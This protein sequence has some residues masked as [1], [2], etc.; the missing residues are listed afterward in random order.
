MTTLDDRPRLAGERPVVPL[1]RR[2]QAPSLRDGR[3]LAGVVLVLASV[4]LG[5]RVVGAAAR[6][7]PVVALTRDLPAGHVVTAG[8]LTTQ[9]VHLTSTKAYVTAAGR[10]E[11]LG[12]RLSRPVTHGELLPA[13]ALAAPG[14]V[15]TA[16]V[17]VRVDSG[18]SPDLAE[19][20]L[21]DVWSTFA[22]AGEGQDK[23]CAT[24]VVAHG[25]EVTA[26]L[27]TSGADHA[28][29]LAVP[30]EEVGAVV[31]AEATTTV[32][33]T[34]HDVNTT[35]APAPTT[36]IAGFTPVGACGSAR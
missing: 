15:D 27:D 31:H 7:T 32:V 29:V 11:V 22:T 34:R 6:T 4:V 14:R 21:V 16:Q 17:P 10:G 20:E 12:R 5:A 28:V 13:S 23:G 24:V 26:S 36:Q 25:L 3:L 1:A 18:R 33:L 35:P 30:A 9:D 19:G 8:D 2:R